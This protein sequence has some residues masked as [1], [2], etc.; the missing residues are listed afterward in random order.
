MKAGGTPIGPGTVLEWRNGANSH[1]WRVLGVHLGATGQE[2]LI[3]MES[4][5]HRPGDI[6]HV[7]P[8]PFHM[9]A[10]FVP[11]VLTRDLVIVPTE[12]V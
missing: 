7:V 6:P 10:A 1:R 11:E 4:I 8:A 5:T 3:E 9:Q 12:N 2:S